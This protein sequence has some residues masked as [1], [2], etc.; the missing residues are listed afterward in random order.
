MAELNS[1]T[2]DKAHAEAVKPVFLSYNQLIARWGLSRTKFYGMRK[3]GDTPPIIQT[4]FGPRFRLRE[5][6]AV[7]ESWVVANVG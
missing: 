4:P 5:V 6:I 7:E 2:A 3:A 1:T